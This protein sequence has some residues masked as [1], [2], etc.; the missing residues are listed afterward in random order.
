MPG[1][2]GRARETAGA[3]TGFFFSASL[4]A[5][6]FF[7][8]RKAPTRSSGRFPRAPA[9]AAERR[10]ATLA[11][12]SE[13]TSRGDRPMRNERLTAVARAAVFCI[14]ALTLGSGAEAAGDKAAY[15]QAKASAK[16][17]YDAA[18]ARCDARSGTAKDIC[19]AEAKAA[20]TKTEV[21]AEA[22]YKDTPK[23]R[24]HAVDEKAEADYK[25][26][27]ERCGERTG[28][29]KDVC[30]KVA[31]AALVRAK[32]DAKAT[33]KSAEAHLEAAKDK[34]EADYRVAAEKCEAMSGDAKS[35]CLAQAKAKYGM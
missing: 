22:A 16:A 33:K 8:G 31:R 3:C 20:R 25:V 34:R 13:P 9:D 2:F 1:A 21:D 6:L 11:P 23:A 10:V 15:E 5:L 4:C 30:V 27:K 17:T 29:D 18:K 19:V 32:A 28:N 12:E 24:E 14:G 7:V 26:S 35:A